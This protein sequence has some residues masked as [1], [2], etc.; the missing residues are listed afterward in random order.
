MELSEYVNDNCQA[1]QN[2]VN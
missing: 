2:E 1:S